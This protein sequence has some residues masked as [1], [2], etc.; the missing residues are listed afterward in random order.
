VSAHE[1]PRSTQ[2]QL[3]GLRPPKLP[4]GELTPREL[5]VLELVTHGLTNT[6]IARSLSVSV[7]TVKFHL[8]SVYRKLDVS[9]RTEAAAAALL[10]NAGPLATNYLHELEAPPRTTQG[11]GPDLTHLQGASLL[12]LPGDGQPSIAPS[13]VGRVELRLDVGGA[14]EPGAAGAALL[15]A[16]FAALLGRYTG[17]ADVYV[18]VAPQPS[19]RPGLIPIS[20]D[21]STAS[22]FGALVQQVS[23]R[24][25]AGLRGG[26]VAVDQLTAAAPP[27]ELGRSPLTQ[28]LFT[29]GP[30]DPGLDVCGARFDLALRISPAGDQLRATLLFDQ[31]LFVGETAARQLSH[32]HTLLAAGLADP[33]QPLRG[34][35]VLTADERSGLLVD[36]NATEHP[37]PACRADELIAGRAAAAPEKV[38]AEAGGELV[39]YAE[40]DQRANRLAQL[41]QALGVEPGVLVGICTERS[42]DMVVGLLAVM[43]AGGAYVPIDPGFPADRQRFMLEDADVRVLLTQEPLLPSLPPHGAEVVCLDRDAGRI[44]AAPGGAPHCAATPEDLAYVIYTSGSTGRPK[45]VQIP[46]RALV[47]F[48]TTMAERPGLTAE[49]VLV[50]VT[51]LSFDIAGLELY[52]PLVQGAQVVLASREAAADPG[53]LAALLERTGATVVQATPTTWRMLID[54][55]WMPARPLKVLCGGEALSAVLAEQLLERGVDLWNMYGPT[56]TTIWSTVRHVTTTTGPPTIGRPIANTTL[57]ILDEQLEPVPVGVP[58]ELH[59]GGHGLAHGYLKRPELTAERFVQHPFD[60]TPGARIYKTGDLARY[61]SDGDVEFLGRLD[62]QVKVRGFRIELGEIETALARHPGVKAAVATTWEETPGDVRLVG[63]VIPTGEPVSS[64][65]LRRSLSETLPSYMVPSAIVSLL[66]FPITP[67]G[68]IDRKSLP[69]PTFERDSEQGYLAPRTALEKQLT[70]IW[71]DVLDIRPIGV[72]DNFFDLGA[73]SIVAAQ[74]FARIERTLR[75]KLPLA[76]VFQAPTVEQLAHLLES[77]GGGSRWTSLVPIQPKGSQPPIFCLHGGAGTILHL[78]PLARHLGGDQ[79]FYGLQARGLYG[80]VAPLRRV[81]EMAVHYLSELRTVQPHGPYYLAGYC[82]GTIIAFEMAQRLV[83]EGEGIALL[84]MFNGP[85][86]AWIRQY[87]GPWNQPSR[88]AARAQAAPRRSNIHRVVGVLTNPKKM[89]HWAHHLTWR[90]RTAIVDPWLSRACIKFDWPLPERMRESHFLNIC[91]QAEREY[92]PDFYSGQI[93]MFYGEGL[94]DDPTLGWEGL[95]ESIT[96]F[97]VPG[98]HEDNREAMHDPYVGFIGDRLR[99]ILEELRNGGP[100]A[101]VAMTSA[102]A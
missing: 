21:L 30:D 77:E 79:P 60:A 2:A 64:A 8:G 66:A 17:R 59:I 49:D 51:T 90:A 76:P 15:L 83:R 63:Y 48:L 89:R 3:A 43:K 32:L 19:S 71:E 80:G 82:F 20:T 101:V 56:E 61:R 58:G 73:T 93:F 50:A 65:Q 36:W 94:Y 45:G 62:H 46:H 81:E 52:L 12:D 25:E 100:P 99:E 38:A 96:S 67:N 88:V 22:S 102:G 13:R 41:L 24:L 47:N 44:A 85:S 29:Y 1:A 95:A 14:V 10:G 84:A 91:A 86:P 68:K 78:E 37:Y 53:E 42:L 27:D 70:A 31:E 26:A 35:P 6:A 33:E 55:G 97:A 4:Q 40:L 5:E 75:T 23:A 16:A 39:T 72:T 98:Q 18:S 92:E 28:V 69:A 74:L 7:H 34:L 54:V 9:N 57:Y 87:G 11:T